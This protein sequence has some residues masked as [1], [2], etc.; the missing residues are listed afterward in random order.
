MEHR[1]FITEE[2]EQNKAREIEKD[3]KL[4]IVSKD[5]INESLGRSPDFAVMIAMRM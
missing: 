1:Q 3:G 4:K 2:L 5:E